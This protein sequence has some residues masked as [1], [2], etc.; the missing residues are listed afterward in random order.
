MNLTEIN[1]DHT[2]LNWI[3]QK[4]PLKERSTI[5]H[6]ERGSRSPQNCMLIFAT[7]HFWL[8]K[9]TVVFVN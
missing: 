8:K 3:F 9:S 1:I 2:R 6:D 5:S 4:A 7:N